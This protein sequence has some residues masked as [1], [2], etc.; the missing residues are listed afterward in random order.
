MGAADAR[1]HL[2]HHTGNTRSGNSALH[3]VAVSPEHTAVS[4][5][6]TASERRPKARP[7]AMRCVL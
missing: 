7:R 5:T 1:P 6:P 3:I 2:D 4:A